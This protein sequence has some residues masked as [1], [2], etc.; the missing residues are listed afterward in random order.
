MIDRSENGTTKG[1]STSGPRARQSHKVVREHPAILRVSAIGVAGLLSALMVTAVAPPIIADQSDRAVVNAPV[2]LLTAPIDG[3][4][5]SLTM[6]PG[7]AV[8]AGYAL[9]RISNVR[10]DRGTLISL[11]EKAAEAREKLAAV[12]ANK[13]ADGAV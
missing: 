9:A 12:V 8:E 10:L 11:Q 1:S 4:I 2:T 13:N 5:D 7:H 3:E 6:N